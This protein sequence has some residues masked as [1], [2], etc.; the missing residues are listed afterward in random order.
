MPRGV[1]V[2]GVPLGFSLSS[3]TTAKGMKPL[4]TSGVEMG[5]GVAVGG[6]NSLVGVSLKMGDG[7][8][9][10]GWNSLV[11]VRVTTG[12]GVTPSKGYSLQATKKRNSRS[13]LAFKIGLKVNS[14]PGVEERIPLS[15]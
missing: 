9:V 5:R 4:C 1:E 6:L 8:A 13:T 12:S 15:I 2:E 7:V 3:E 11:G 10:G 14:A